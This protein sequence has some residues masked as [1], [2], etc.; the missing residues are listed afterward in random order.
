MAG[1][2]GLAQRLARYL[3]GKTASFD[4]TSPR[5]VLKRSDT[6]KLRERILALSQSEARKIGI[7]KSTMHYLRKNAKTKDAF[8]LY[9]KV[10]KKL[11]E[12]AA[13]N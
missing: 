7:G 2:R 12:P 5:P 1:P 6:R 4:L 10:S 9:G 3:L 8:S 11:C 13:S